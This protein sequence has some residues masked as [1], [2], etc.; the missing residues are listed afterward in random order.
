M[1]TS[2]RPS[3][4][5]LIENAARSALWEM[6]SR[7]STGVHAPFISSE[8]PLFRSPAFY[9]DMVQPIQ[10]VLRYGRMSAKTLISKFIKFSSLFRSP[11][12]LGNDG[13]LSLKF[14]FHGTSYQAQLIRSIA[15]SWPYLMMKT[16][17]SF[18]WKGGAPYLDEE[19][20][21]GKPLVIRSILC[22]TLVWTRTTVV[23]LSF[24]NEF[25][26]HL[27]GLHRPHVNSFTGD[28]PKIYVKS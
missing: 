10:Y 7:S 24:A 11:C 9:D 22:L 5:D 14:F 27:Q 2:F 21:K 26:H 13:S 23:L 18:S 4:R 16:P 3:H 12:H 8:K 28:I 6:T 19:T 20:R 15:M 1:N 25:A 17:I